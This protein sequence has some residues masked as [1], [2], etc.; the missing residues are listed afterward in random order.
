MKKSKMFRPGNKTGE[1]GTPQTFDDGFRRCKTCFSSQGIYG[2]P[3][4]GSMMITEM[5]RLQHKDAPC[6]DIGK[7]IRCVRCGYIGDVVMF[8]AAAEYGIT[9]AAV[10]TLL[11]D[12]R[13]TAT[14]TLKE[15]QDG[16]IAEVPLSPALQ[17]MLNK[18]RPQWGQ[19]YNPDEHIEPGVQTEFP[20]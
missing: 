12:H 11:R 18:P 4:V 9:K 16:R 17:A 5:V 10:F 14:F 7:T 2:Q 3:D 8:R 19:D 1:E 6:I 13:A 20:L 15:L